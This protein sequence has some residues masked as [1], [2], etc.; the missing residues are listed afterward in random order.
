[1]VR[2]KF[3]HNP[4]TDDVKW[5]YIS[6]HGAIYINMETG[7]HT[8]VIEIETSRG[9]LDLELLDSGLNEIELMDLVGDVSPILNH[10]QIFPTHGHHKESFSLNV[11]IVDPVTRYRRS[12]YFKHFN[13]RIIRDTIWNDLKTIEKSIVEWVLSHVDDAKPDLELVANKK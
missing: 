1:M 2:V 11:S 9:L 3:I 4:T 13:L 6:K 5:E 12:H 8:R 7:T 10:I